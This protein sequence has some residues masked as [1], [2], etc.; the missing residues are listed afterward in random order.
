MAEEEGAVIKCHTIEEW[1]EQIELAQESK[2]LVIVDFT[3]AW[4]VPCRMIAPIFDELAKKFVDVVFLKVD[5]D[6]LKTIAQEW[7]ITAMPTFI[8][9]KEGTLLDKLVGAN[10][11][12]LNEK[13]EL[14]MT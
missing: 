5:V 13:I 3:A 1:N 8:F 10:E 12:E 6:D 2:Q 14:H 7:E 9:L 4:C 11:D